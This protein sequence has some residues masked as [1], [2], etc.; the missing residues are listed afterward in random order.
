M[1]DTEFFRAELERA[2]PHQCDRPFFHH[3]LIFKVLVPQA[4]HRLLEEWTEYLIAR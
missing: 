2:V 3:V 1:I 4:R